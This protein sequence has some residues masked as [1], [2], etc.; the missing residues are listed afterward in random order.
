MSSRTVSVALQAKVDQY[1]A[2]MAA[3]AKGTDD[4]AK[5]AESAG[6]KVDESTKGAGLAFADLSKQVGI[7]VGESAGA[8]QKLSGVSAS[9][10]KMDQ[11]QKQAWDTTGKAVATAGAGLTAFNAIVAKT[12]IEYNTLQ[13]TSRAALSTMLGGAEAAGEQMEK[14]DAFARTSPFA[15]QTFVTAQQ[16]MLAFGIETEKVIP[17]L[18]ALNDATAA[19]GGNSQQLGELAF[20]MAQVSSAGKITAQ[21]LMQFGQRGVNAAELIGSQMGKTAAQI[22]D[23][24]TAG[25][26]DANTALDALAAGM[27]EKFDGA[28]ANVKETMGGA[29]DRVSAAWR[30]MSATIMESAVSQDGGGW[31]VDLTN[32]AADTLRWFQQLPTPV[33]ETGAAL[34]AL[35]G[36]G[37]V[38]V[39]GLMVV[40]PKTVEAIDA[41]RKLGVEIPG[42]EKAIRS[43]GKVAGTAAVGIAGLMVFGEIRNQIKGALPEIEQA[44]TV[45][46]RLA[47]GASFDTSDIFKSSNGKDVAAG[48]HDVASAFD[49]L[50]GSANNWETATRN[51][52]EMWSDLTMSESDRDRTVAALDLIDQSLS[53]MSADEAAQAFQRLKASLPS[54]TDEQLV[55]Q[56]DGY[57]EAMQ[58]MAA[59]A[60]YAKLSTEQLVEAMTTGQ[61]P[62][63]ASASAFTSLSD[64]VLAL[65][66]AALSA[67]GVQADLTGASEQAAAAAEQQAEQF[68]AASQAASD[69]IGSYQGLRDAIQAVNDAQREGAARNMEQ[70]A[71]NDQWLATLDEVD[72]QIKK[73][74][75]SLDENTEKGRANREFL[76]GM[77]E[78]ARTNTD[79]LLANGSSVD[80]VNAK[81]QT[82]QGEFLAQIERF[83]GAEAAAEQ[84][85]ISVGELASWYG[86]IP[87]YVETVMA[88][89]GAQLSA[90]EAA[91]VN[92]QIKNL[93]LET[94]TIIATIAN[95]LGVEEA[96]RYIDS[97]P[98]ET[99]KQLTIDPDTTGATQVEGAI[100]GI[101]NSTT[102]DV[103]VDGDTSGADEAKAAIDAVQSK[104]VTVTTRFIDLHTSNAGAPP[105]SLARREA[106]GGVLDFYARGGI[107]EN[108]V[109]QIA[110][111]GSWRVWA[112]PETGGEA[113]I[114][115]A[116]AKRIRSLEIWRETGRRL[117]VTGPQHFADGGVIGQHATAGALSRPGDSY[118][119]VNNVTNYH[120]EGR[121][122]L[123]WLVDN[124]R[125]GQRR[126]YQTGGV[127]G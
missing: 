59:E 26:L 54:A 53:S 116:A 20:V 25:T 67:S 105:L 69:A 85:G 9:I 110:P 28:S 95:T 88:V 31:L 91:K 79:A 96:Q 37:A 126:S 23:D 38:G 45:L 65:S 15:K 111:A 120:F 122:A 5:A 42:A 125:D 7:S 97:I 44:E 100:D 46:T 55:E 80:V 63:S 36:A 24:I 104:T 27:S 60:G 78:D 22:R 58:R 112:E 19:A 109:A 93:P 8:A 1:L 61:V 6:K 4:V 108:H 64:S 121:E 12:G 118:A 115:L 87:N 114:P 74:G 113:Y 49:R 98:P 73:N 57:G 16:Q 47:K 72:A 77:A 102:K 34:G 35:A 117:G 86:L 3:A 18:D 56:F 14:L 32:Q 94:K 70:Q 11:D 51:W 2:A 21:D 66:D 29:L 106:D 81:M 124:L 75:E 89:E 10:R 119:S 43:F 82:M 103:V 99:L 83:G 107:R 17:Y 71:A 13:Q 30:D 50:Y 62:S 127:H 76:R 92:E 48:V 101:P 52:D 33:L 90:D 41:F 68:E 40:I 84:L 123:G 39:G